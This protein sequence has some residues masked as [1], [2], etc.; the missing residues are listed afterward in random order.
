[1]MR[2][3]LLFGLAAGLAVVLALESGAP[4]EAPDIAAALP[5]PP[6]G[7][8]GAPDQA[9]LAALAPR[10]L[11]RPLFSPDRRPATRTVPAPDATETELPRL[12]GVIVG[13]ARRSAIFADTAGHPHV[14]AEGAGIGRFTV[15]RIAPG[16]VTVTSSE[17]ERVLR[18]SYADARAPDVATAPE[19]ERGGAQ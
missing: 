4:D 3:L 19:P 17:G 14:A 12:A 6:P 5:A 10:L 1:M 7:T 9:V 11:G 2:W 13:P 18:P 8:A 15:R 16:Q